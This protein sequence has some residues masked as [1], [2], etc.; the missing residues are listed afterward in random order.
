MNRWYVVHARP[1]QERRAEA[2]L[3]RQGFR[4]W[5]PV[6]ERSRRHA[7]RIETVR[8]ALF[9]GY[10]FVEL[11]I[12]RATWRAINGTFGV[13]R[14][15]ADGLYPQARRRCR[16]ISLPRCGARSAPTASAR[17]RLPIYSRVTR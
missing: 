11:D 12:E 16:R 7:R 14:L 1:H 9:P 5:L 10:L 4:V 6:M 3:L 13:R 15:L 17:R 8:S 2:N